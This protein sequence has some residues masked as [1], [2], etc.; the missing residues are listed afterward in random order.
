MCGTITGMLYKSTLGVVPC[1]VGGLVGAS[2]IGGLT[3]LIEEGNRRGK[4]AFEM[5]FWYLSE[6]FIH[7]S[8]YN[9]LD[10]YMIKVNLNIMFC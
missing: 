2:L 1:I 4:I 10:I 5:K 7:I 9:H 6:P 3:L 8:C